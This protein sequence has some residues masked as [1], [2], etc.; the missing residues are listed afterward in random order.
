MSD[1]KLGFVPEMFLVQFFG[2]NRNLPGS[3]IRDTRS[4]G[5]KDKSPDPRL[6]LVVEPVLDSKAEKKNQKR[7]QVVMGL[8]PNL[9]RELKICPLCDSE[10]PLGRG[11]GAVMALCTKAEK[12]EL[13]STSGSNG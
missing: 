2:K 5:V 3:T 6:D 11:V 13:G 4:T 12:S 1:Q 9:R 8:L 7:K 10:T